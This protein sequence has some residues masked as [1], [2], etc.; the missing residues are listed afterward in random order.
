MNAAQRRKSKRG[1]PHIITMW[2]APSDI[3]FIHD[4]RV[5]DARRWCKRKSIDVRVD[6]TW[7]HAEF[8]FVKEKDA[9]Y[10]AL[11]WL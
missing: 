2:P 5:T 9:V 4:D 3:Y 8:K 6:S 11:T 1:Y 10:F 7:N